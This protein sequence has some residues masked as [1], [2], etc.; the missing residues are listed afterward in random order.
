MIQAHS[1]LMNKAELS[2]IM[3]QLPSNLR[4]AY[5]TN[6]TLTWSGTPEARPVAFEVNHAPSVSMTLQVT[7]WLLNSIG[8]ERA[9][10]ESRRGI[11]QCASGEERFVGRRTAC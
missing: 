8:M 2:P 6:I 4:A 5:T 1:F 11:V 7:S 9:F 10:V 3:V